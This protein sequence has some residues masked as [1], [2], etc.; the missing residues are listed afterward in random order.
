[1]FIISHFDQSCV[2]KVFTVSYV[3][4]HTDNLIVLGGKLKIFRLDRERESNLE[5]LS[6]LL[7]AKQEYSKEK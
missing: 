3:W 1:M 4:G 6:I 5:N 7:G 2:R